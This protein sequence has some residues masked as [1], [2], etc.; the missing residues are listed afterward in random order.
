MPA[1]H[2]DGKAVSSKIRT[3]LIRVV[4]GLK[5]KGVHPGLAMVMVGANNASALYVNMKVKACRELGID[6][7]IVNLP[8]S[9]SRQELMETV[10]ALNLDET[11]DGILI[12]LP[13]PSHLQDESIFESINPQKDV[14]CFHPENQARLLTGKEGL[15]PCTPLGCIA[16]L[17]RSGIVLEG[18]K[19]VIVGRSNIV[20]KPLALMLLQE[21]AT[22]TVCHSKTRNLKEEIKQAELL[23][24]AIGKPEAVSGDDLKP[25][26]IV[27]DVGQHRLEDGRIVGDVNYESALPNASW[28]TPVPGGTGPMTVAVLMHNTMWAAARR[29]GLPFAYN[30]DSF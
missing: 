4:E 10:A 9:A 13:L 7:R 27:V 29:R 25:G 15:K 16:L 28:I 30:L 8:E 14:D 12:Q 23:I 21:N 3:E 22:T 24:V 18:K 6:S 20:G 1:K 17:K 19:S 26:C 5:R 11:V 2:L